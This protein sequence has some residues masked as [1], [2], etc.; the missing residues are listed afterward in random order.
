VLTPSISGSIGIST[1]QHNFYYAGMA[2]PYKVPVVVFTR[3]PFD[4]ILSGYEYH[5]AYVNTGPFD[6]YVGLVRS[7]R[8]TPSHT[9]STPCRCSEGLYSAVLPAMSAVVA[10]Q[11]L[12]QDGHGVIRA[13]LLAPRLFTFVDPIVDGETYCGYLER[14]PFTSGI[15]VEMLRMSAFPM[16][17]MLKAWRCDRNENVLRVCLGELVSNVTTTVSRIAKHLSAYRSTAQTAGSIDE[18]KIA[19]EYTAQF[20]QSKA[21]ASTYASG[22]DRHHAHTIM[23]SLDIYMFNRSFAVLEKIEDCAGTVPGTYA[24]VVELSL[25]RAHCRCYSLPCWSRTNR[26]AFHLQP[27]PLSEVDRN[28][29]RPG[30]AGSNIRVGLCDQVC[31]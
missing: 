23:R 21:H 29:D 7:A 18:G 13:V 25:H 1:A 26:T 31:V 4:M 3:N 2:K 14:L 8:L 9:L 12:P 22:Y 6:S 16:S 20:K 27:T 17:D 19:E 28:S 30:L 5:K 11:K 15:A 24:H 10:G